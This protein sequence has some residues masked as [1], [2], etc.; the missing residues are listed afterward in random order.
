MLGSGR[1]FAPD[2]SLL[3]LVIVWVLCVALLGRWC[4]CCF[5][6]KGDGTWAL[7]YLFGGG[8]DGDAKGPSLLESNG[9]RAGTESYSYFEVD[10][11]ESQGRLGPGFSCAGI[12]VVCLYKHLILWIWVKMKY[13]KESRRQQL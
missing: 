8:G 12:L 3:W 1:N 11:S 6:G 7:E 2:I 4:A 13:E 10:C 9:R 5:V